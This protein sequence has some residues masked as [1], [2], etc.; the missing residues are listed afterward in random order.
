MWGYTDIHHL[1][2]TDAEINS[3]RSNEALRLWWSAIGKSPLNKTDYDSFEP[4]DSEK[5][6]PLRSLFYAMAVRQK[7]ITQ[8]W[9]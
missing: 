6:I 1:Q 5:G 3:I 9:A 2:P 4:R 8:K 7:E